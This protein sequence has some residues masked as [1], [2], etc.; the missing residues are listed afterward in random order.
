MKTHSLLAAAAALVGA[1]SAA[2]NPLQLVISQDGS[3][4]VQVGSWMTLK[5]GLTGYRSNGAWATGLV[6]TQGAP[7]PGADAWGTFTATTITWSGAFATTF[8]VYDTSPAIAFE[9][10]ALQNIVPGGGSRENVSSAFPSWTLPTPSTSSAGFLQFEGAFIDGGSNGENAGTFD[11]AGASKMTSGL[12][13]GPFVLFDTTG[14]NTLIISPS[15]S[16]MSTNFALVG[17]TLAVGA[18][19]SVDVIP[20]GHSSSVVM[21]YGSTGINPTIMTWGAALLAAYGKASTGS[22]TDYTNTRLM[23]NTDHGEESIIV[24]SSARPSCDYLP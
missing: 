11:T 2:T 13:G 21:W 22:K 24:W 17:Q 16:F 18:L 6:P 19:G 7:Q 15:S 4:A 1:A 9:Q 20:A 23:Y 14:A 10:M 5:S 12:K 3:Y 8:K